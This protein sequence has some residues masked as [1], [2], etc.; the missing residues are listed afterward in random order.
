MIRQGFLA[1]CLTC[2]LLCPISTL[3]ATLCPETLTSA[4]C[5]SKFPLPFD[6]PFGQ[7]EAPARNRKVR[8]MKMFTPGSISA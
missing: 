8:R 6:F 7:Y 3:L 1:E 2:A 4:D 5:F